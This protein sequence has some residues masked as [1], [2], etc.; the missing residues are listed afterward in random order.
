M[1][2]SGGSQWWTVAVIV[3]KVNRERKDWCKVRR[4]VVGIDKIEEEKF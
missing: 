3:D 4:K 2:A 1:V